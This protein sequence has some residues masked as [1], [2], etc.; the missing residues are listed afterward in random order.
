MKDPRFSHTKRKKLKLKKEKKN[1]KAFG[2]KY[3]FLAYLKPKEFLF[4]VLYFFDGWWH[5]Q[6]VKAKSEGQAV[7]SVVP[8]E[9]IR[10]GRYSV[11]RVKS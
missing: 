11:A 10:L 9:S 4:N 1:K 7:H 2:T 3:D 5:E 6:K 8:D